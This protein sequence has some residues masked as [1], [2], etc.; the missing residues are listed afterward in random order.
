MLSTY[1]LVSRWSAA[2]YV[3]QVARS[4]GSSR[5]GMKLRPP[6]LQVAVGGLVTLNLLLAVVCVASREHTVRNLA[7]RATRAKLA[8]MLAFRVLDRDEGDEGGDG[9]DGGDGGGGAAEAGRRAPGAAADRRDDERIGFE[10]FRALLLELNRWR[11]GCDGERRAAG[12]SR[13]ARGR[14]GGVGGSRS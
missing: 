13:R 14:R 9:G 10:S 7:A 1:S 2:Y 8:L 12:P 4:A 5:S 6:S 11:A 3:F